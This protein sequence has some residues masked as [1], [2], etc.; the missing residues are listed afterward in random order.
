VNIHTIKPIDEE[1]IAKCAKETGAIFTVEDHS[2]IGGMGGAVA[3][4][5]ARHA[6]VPVYR[7]GLDNCFGESGSPEDLYRKYDLDAEG[8]AKRVREFS[9][10]LK[11]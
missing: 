1:L 6:P 11:G 8:I 9:K 5:A 3:E 7:W 4:A 10:S 2:T